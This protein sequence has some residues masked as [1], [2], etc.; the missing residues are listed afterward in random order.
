MKLLMTLLL[1]LISSGQLSASDGIERWAVVPQTDLYE[2]KVGTF[3]ENLV[4]KDA[5]GQNQHLYSQDR[6]LTVLTIFDID[7]PISLK[8]VPKI[9]RLEKEFPKV[10]FKHVYISK[11]ASKESV[12]T[13]FDKRQYKGQLLIDQE[14][15][16]VNQL[17]IKTTCENFVIDS[18]GTL[19]YRGAV[20]DQYG[21]SLVKA[22]PE[23]NYLKNA[24]RSLRQGEKITF[25]LTGAPG[26]LVA[27]E[28]ES[29]LK[30]TELTFNKE[31]SRILQ[32]KCQH[33]HRKGGVGPFELM[34]Y[35]QVKERR[36]MIKYAV[37]KD[38][39]PPWF[40]E[41]GG[42]WL[43]N[44]D[45]SSEE[46]ETLLNW[47]SAGAPEGDIQQAPAPRNWSS[48]GIIENPDLIVKFPKVKVQAEGFMEYE[49]LTMKIPITEDKWVKAVET[50]TKNP[51]VLHHALSFVTKSKRAKGIN[52][53]GGFFSG[54]VP[55]TTINTFP[56]GTGKFLPK[57]SYIIIQLHYTPNGTA[58]EDQVSLAFDFYDEKPQYEMLTKSAFSRDIKI[59]PHAANHM[60][61]AEHRFKENGYLAGFN[62]HAHL[63][64]KSFKYELIQANGKT[65]TLIDIPKY[66]FNWQIN[67]QL[68]K[69][70]YVKSGSIVRVS[71]GFDNSSNNKANPNP[72][73]TVR[74]G[75]QTNN[76]MMI[77]Y[78]EW[79]AES[80]LKE[81]DGENS[82]GLLP[83]SL[84][85]HILKVKQKL[86]SGDINKQDAKKSIT[87]AVR[88]GIASGE[89]SQQDMVEYIALIKTEF[90][91]L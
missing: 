86:Q 13:E 37:S 66:D 8:Q 89:Y 78:F 19:K 58:V 73:V 71:A 40:A 75:E 33:C 62:P 48:K 27:S 65:E 17:K 15:L 50:R 23:N 72:A 9:Q 24:L 74:F 56:E 21:I 63:R 52:P 55:G 43:H 57:G 7:C 29:S 69:P 59:P 2:N 90:R 49:H 34:T 5:N 84:K 53:I 30:S 31:I 42:P 36:K 61:V 11:L 64:G 83:K 51:Q 25:P 38:I 18:K 3:I 54:Y 68:V 81:G 12:V 10:V 87:Q 45:L 85:S 20:D 70:I 77:G 28:M 82:L 14:G 88:S 44:Y 35:E 4:L 32:D 22:H 67:Y 6:V 80:S 1:V 60:I 79:Y 46:K 47:L 41:A 39:M 16:F 26:C 91:N 76:E